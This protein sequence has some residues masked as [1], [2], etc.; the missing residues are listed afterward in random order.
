MRHLSFLITSNLLLSILLLACDKSDSPIKETTNL[1]TTIQYK[2]IDGV[3][4]N[5]L[6]LDIHYSSSTEQKKPVVI[7]VHGGAWCLGDKT[8]QLENKIKLFQKLNYVFVS[9]NYRLSPFPHQLNNPDRIMYPTHNQDIADAIKWV[10]DNIS[11]YGGEANKIAL[12]GHS[13]GGHL[14]ALTGT[15]SSFLND[16]GLNLSNIKGIAVIDTEGYDIAPKI[17]DNNK[18]YINAFGTDSNLNTQ[19]SPIHNIVSGVSYPKFFIAKRGN[20][21]RIQIAND[22]INTLKQNGVFVSQI[23]GSI[24]SHSEINQAIGKDGEELIT[25]ELKLFLKNCFQ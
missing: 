22:F 20:T 12:L 14:V 8:N 18:N 6:S 19:A 25:N 1:S 10:F 7:Y 3:E 4:P 21:N 15:N 16:V 11:R 5:L 13:A 2:Q 9:V 23:N 24:Y 17:T